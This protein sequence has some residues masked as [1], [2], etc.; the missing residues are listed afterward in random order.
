MIPY[1]VPLYLLIS[2][3][4]LLEFLW[5]LGLLQVLGLF[6]MT[7]H[8]RTSYMN[9]LPLTP[10]TSK[11][12]LAIQYRDLIHNTDMFNIRDVRYKLVVAWPLYWGQG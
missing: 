5:L 6:E 12:D 11:I 3:S 7:V 2:L 10:M 9:Y 8:H 4:L 1:N